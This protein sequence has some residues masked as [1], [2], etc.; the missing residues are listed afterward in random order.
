MRPTQALRPA[1]GSYSVT[2]A[3]LSIHTEMWSR[4]PYCACVGD[5]ALRRAS[6]PSEVVLEYIDWFRVT[7]HIFLIPG[8]GPTA[9]F[10]AADNRVEYV[11][12][13]INLFHFYVSLPKLLSNFLVI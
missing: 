4:F 7:S 5:Q 2:F 8:E 12:V 6:V 9:A 13:S 1:Q 11:R 3:S 10:G